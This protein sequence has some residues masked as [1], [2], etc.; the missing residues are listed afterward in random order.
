MK[1][2][3]I[4]IEKQKPLNKLCTFGIGGPARYYV[5]IT[6]VKQLQKLLPYVDS[7]SLPYFVLG[8]GSNILFDD[9]GF[10][11]IVI[12]NKIS[13]L[14]SSEQGLFSVGAGH[15]F[16][17]L[18][19]LTARQGWSGL[20]F[21]SGIPGSVGGAVFM[22]AGANGV[23]TADSLTHVEFISMDGELSKIDKSTLDFSYRT[24]PFQQKRGVISGAHFLLTPLTSSK[25]IQRKILD[26]RLE[27]QPYGEKSAGCIFRNPKNDSAGALIERCGLKGLSVGDA[28]VSTQ[29]ANFIINKGHASAVD[30]LKL[31]NLLKEKLFSSTGIHLESEVRYIPYQIPNTQMEDQ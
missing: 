26:Y 7:L 19:A 15:S 12:H 11:G 27:T 21:A 29:H 24:S 22:N 5:E 30:V 9:R 2:P 23:E 8:K 18:G 13:Y 4:P 6:Q 3:P 17:R 31:M 10:D 16:A 20:E 1:N 25:S 14:E 28:Q